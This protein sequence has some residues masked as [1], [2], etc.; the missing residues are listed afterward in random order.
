MRRLAAE[1]PRAVLLSN[2]DNYL[3]D[4]KG[5]MHVPGLSEQVW[6]DG[7]RRTYARLDQLGIEIIVMRGLP[8]VP[9]NVPSCLSR[10]AAE[11]P[12]ATECAFTPD[13]AFMARA[14]RMQ[15]EA[16]R[17]LPVRFI[18]MN[19]LVCGTGAGRCRTEREGLVLYTDDNHITR[20]LSRAMAPTLG[21]RLADALQR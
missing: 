13:R 11:L 16:A 2:S 14:R 7:L 12:F 9:F 18:D 4:R 17:G 21:E 6:M 19:D 1:R 8:W 3:T 10:R 15:D 20:T 5:L